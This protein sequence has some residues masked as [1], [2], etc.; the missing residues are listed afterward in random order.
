MKRQVKTKKKKQVFN[1][2]NL[3][4]VAFVVVEL[5]FVIDSSITGNPIR[6]AVKEVISTSPV[7][8]EQ[9]KEPACTPTTEIC[10]GKDNDCD[11]EIDE[12]ELCPV[13]YGCVNSL[14]KLK[15]DF[16]K[17]TANSFTTLSSEKTNIQKELS[18]SN[19][20]PPNIRIDKIKDDI[21]KKS[22]TWT[23][24]LNPIFL[25]TDEE[26]KMLCGLNGE[27]P[28]LKKIITKSENTIL[29]D[30]F[31]WRDKHGNDYITS[32]KDQ[33]NCGSCW[34]FAAVAALESHANAYYNNPNLDLNLSEQ[35][36][37][38]CFHGGG[39]GG[40]SQDQIEQIFSNYYQNTGIAK[41]IC[42]PY[43][44]TNNNC[45]NKCSNW[46]QD[47]WKSLGYVNIPLTVE[48][49]KQAVINYGPVEVGMTVYNDFFS[50]SGGIYSHTTESIA[51][52]HAVTIVGFGVYDGIDYWIVKNSWGTNWG[53]E[54]YFKIAVGDSDIDSRFAFAV[55]EPNPPEVQ[56]VICEDNDG[57]GYCNWGIGEKPDNCPVCD[58]VIEDCDNSNASVFEGCGIN[59]EPTGFLSITSNP[60]ESKVY[61]KDLISSEW[62][63]RGSAPLEIELNVGERQVKLTKENYIDYTTSVD[64]FEEQTTELSATLLLSP[65]FSYPSNNS[66]FRAGDLI[67]I[68]G[69]APGPGFINYTIEWGRGKN[70]TEWF[71]DGISLVNE[72]LIE[73]ING[74][75]AIWD[76]SLITEADYYTIKLTV[77]YAESQRYSY[78]SIYL[79]PALKDGFPISIETNTPEIFSV[80]TVV[81][82]DGD[83]LKEIAIKGF[84]K[85]YVYHQNGSLMSGWPK[86]MAGYLSS[87]WPLSP[88]S[89]GDVNNDGKKE[90]FA[91]WFQH[92]GDIDDEGNPI[93]YCLYGWNYNG[94]ILSGF[95]VKCSNDSYEAAHWINPILSDVNGD[96][97]L[98]IIVDMIE[99]YKDID[100]VFVWN[101]KGQ[102]MDNWPAIINFT[103]PNNADQNDMV[104]GD[105]DN[106]GKNDIILKVDNSFFYIFDSNGSIK[107]H[108]SDNQSVP[109][110]LGGK[111]SIAD[112][113]NDKKVEI[114]N[115]GGATLLLFDSNGT[116]VWDGYYQGYSYE[117]SSFGEFTGDN[118]PEIVFGDVSFAYQGKTYII[119]SNNNSI[120]NSWDID[121]PS[122][123]YPDK[124]S[125]LENI[126][127]DINN[128]GK[129]DIIATIWNYKPENNFDEIYAWNYNG[130]MIEGFPKPLNGYSLTSPVIDD[131]DNDGKLEMIAVSCDSSFDNKLF[132]WDLSGNYNANK[133]EWPMFHH[134]VQHTG[135]YTKPT[136]ICSDGTP[137]GQCNASGYKC[138]DG[139][140]YLF[141]DV[142]DDGKVNLG[143]LV[144]L[145]NYLYKYGP[146]PNPLEV[147]DVNSD[148]TV[149][150]GDIVYL[151]NYLF[152]GGS[153]PC[154]SIQNPPAPL[155]KTYTEVEA[156]QLLKDAQSQQAK[157]TLK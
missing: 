34:A 44:A 138:V 151:I 140:L 82:L 67:E 81:D 102:L 77:N 4:L 51:G 33:G 147:G 10:D 128:D 120:L 25:K 157:A 142:N 96:G 154:D 144:F 132:A 85:V 18:Y 141:G 17:K 12:G 22:G 91:A 23:A 69:T 8:V 124:G 7:Q 26:K 126:I 20:L 89:I 137:Y 35:D 105:V 64:I 57:D 29:P 106:D 75:L 21:K 9:V 66:I 60:L 28:P 108:F 146:A 107:N 49:I 71:R 113:N 121:E 90:V 111:L 86:S 100:E 16:Y 63:Y 150:V 114:A 98:E 73:I 134:D 110:G 70:S 103:D 5:V 30:F 50:Y 115:K 58:D 65:K 136:Q 156:N 37:V 143:D 62:I 15:E 83:G 122:N 104:S 47:A 76:T 80:P 59:P 3:V 53:E 152:Y 40:A 84:H 72:G 42:F 112:I 61:V 155:T 39:C 116:L 109:C 130:S 54:G 41:E 133:V 6:S 38:S 135:L 36:L 125:V 145:I 27:P 52:Y 19:R 99:Q 119:Y 48:D 14:C 55:T 56:E 78:V 1:I 148:G 74:S 97:Y 88:V 68:N 117:T 127:A 87:N 94:S 13:G 95:P 93:D 131:I 123:T 11:K 129:N 79:D 2:L 46:Q 153:A 149:S 118:M 24:D 92:P 139:N 43:T 101:Y 32:I 45:A 31:D